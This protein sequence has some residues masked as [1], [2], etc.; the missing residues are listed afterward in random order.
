MRPS[1]KEKREQRIRTEV[2]LEIAGQGVTKPGFEKPGDIRTKV[3]IL[4]REQP[5][6]VAMGIRILG[7]VLEKD[8]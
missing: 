5:Q 3:R 7:R 6:K 8:G 2:P 1:E 4:A